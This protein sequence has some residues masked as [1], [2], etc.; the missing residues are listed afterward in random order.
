[1]I[2]RFQRSWINFKRLYEP[3]ADAWMVYDNSG[4]R[5]ELLEQGP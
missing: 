1:V 5:P 2:R 3:I 4:D